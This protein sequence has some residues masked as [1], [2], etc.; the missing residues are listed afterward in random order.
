MEESDNA[1]DMTSYVDVLI[2]YRWTFLVVAGTILGVG[3]LYALMARPIYRADIMVQVEE[4]NP[5]NNASKLIASISP[6]L[7]VKPAATA[8]MELLRHARWWARKLRNLDIDAK[9][10]YFPLIGASIASYNKE[11]SKPGLFGLA[12]SPGQRVDRPTG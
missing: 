7:D 4:S 12:G 2:R 5:T 11:L 8:E 6:G 3:L 1:V 10:R 9:P